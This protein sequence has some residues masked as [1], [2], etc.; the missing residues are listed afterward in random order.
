MKKIINLLLI[1]ILIG[2]IIVMPCCQDEFLEKEPPGAAAGGVMESSKGLE[3]LLI[4]AYR[5]LKGFAYFGGM[6][7]TDF[8]YG[9]VLSDD[10]YKGSAIGDQSNFDLLERYEWLPSNPYFSERWRDGYNGVARSNQVL[11]F[12]WA[13]QEGDNAIS[14][15]RAKEIEA[16]AKFLRAWFHFK[17]TKVFEKIPYI[18]TENELGEEILPEEIPNDS[19][20]WDEIE[21]DLQFALENLSESYPL[22]EVGRANKYSAMAIKAHVHMYQGE[23]GL[24]KTYLDNIISSNKYRLVDNYND[25]FDM[26]TE[27]NEESIFEIQAA[28]SETNHT[29]LVITGPSMHL[30]G[31]A[32]FGWGFYQPSQNL[33]EAF[34]VTDKG[35]PILDVED[36][37][38]LAHDMGINSEDEFHP[39]DHLIDPR[40]DWTISRRGIDYLGWGICQGKSWIR[41]Q[42]NGGPYMTK[43]YMHKKENANLNLSSPFNNGKN[44]RAY[45]YSHIL[46]WRAEIAV[47]DGDL[48]Y[49]RELVNKI[50]ERA[51]GS[52]VVM[53]RVFTYKFPSGIDVE[54]DWQQP[55]AN[56]KIEPYP[57]GADAFSTQEKAMKAV[58]LEQRLEFATE[59]MRFFD[60][61]RW[62]ID[63]EVLNKYIEQD[64]KFRS[65]LQGAIYDSEKNDYLPL[66]EDQLELQESLKQD[67]AYL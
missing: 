45:R 14:D 8:N 7:A 29:S 38:P 65:F 59:G 21:A 2:S 62:N 39:T 43:K 31:A 53:G 44:F 48:D 25:N 17:L 55:A 24:A 66:P 60:L 3:V 27:N 19:E 20:G 26:A 23:L 41:Q 51:K 50:R 34:Q 22:G 6:M 54:V 40:V 15:S 30:Y 52:E 58:R 42:D 56:Y 13:T 10:C 57:V 64:S 11:Q 47:E 63:N 1:I 12:L 61:R 37:E 33:F 16:E 5:A 35:L 18:K 36:R 67:P 4:G 9:S 32:S 46:L 28:S 49:A